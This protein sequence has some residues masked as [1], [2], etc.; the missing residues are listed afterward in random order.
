MGRHI[1]IGAGGIGRATA[2]ALVERGHE[3]TIG[4]RSGTDPGLPGV[5]AAR[6]DASDG[7]ALAALARGADTLVNA[8]NPSQ[9]HTW[10]RDWPPIAAAMLRAAS[11]AGAGLVT[12][13]NLYGYGPGCGPMTGDLPL[14]PSGPKGRIRARMWADA[15][16]AHQAGDL[17]ATEL[18][19]SDYFGPGAGAGVSILNS[20]VISRAAA[21][22]RV[23]LVSGGPDV[24]HSWTYTD[25]IGTLAAVLATDERS[26]GRPWIV[27]SAEPR[28]V[29]QVAADSAQIAGRPA[30]PVSRAPRAV[31]ALA[32][33]SATVRE[34]DETRYQFEEP[35]VVDATATEN[36]FGLAPTPWRTA[37]ARTV[38]DLASTR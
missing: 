24:V 5:T 16:A 23:W 3:V 33:V 11:T 31:L 2:R 13:S 8:A 29:R 15:L 38:E 25:D 27:P 22:R 1:V 10:A 7:Q 12:V 35:F 34:L 30:P 18:R 4:T 36:T 21:G 19:A 26:W 32:R 28:T 37:L 17:R 6:V 9:Y 14:A 20:F